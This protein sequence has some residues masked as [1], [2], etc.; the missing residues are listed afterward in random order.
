M[1]YFGRFV[2]RYKRFF[3][4]VE[5]EGK[6]ITCHNPNTGS[7]RNLLIENAPVCFSMTENPKRNLPYTLEGIFIDK[8]WIQTNTI[9]ANK[10]VYDAILKGIIDDFGHIISIKREYKIDTKRIDFYIETKDKRVLV[11]V[12]SVSLFDDEYA[13]FPDAKTKRGKEH[14]F[15]LKKSINL[16]FTPYILYLIQSNRE[17]FRCAKEYDDEYCKVYHDVVPKHITPLFYRNIF[18]P[19]SETNR[20]EK[21]KLDK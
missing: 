14:L 4:D 8:H 12:K 18:D 7:M 17:K 10:L 11:E 16:G 2:K 19:Y 21:V 20:I 13:M 5:Y 6:I 9:K 1:L 15:I 3:V